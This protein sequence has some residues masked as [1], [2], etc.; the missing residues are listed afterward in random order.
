MKIKFLVIICCLF[1]S[2]IWS[3]ENGTNSFNEC[4]WETGRIFLTNIRQFDSPD[5]YETTVIMEIRNKSQL[6]DSTNGIYSLSNGSTHQKT[7]FILKKEKEFKIITFKNLIMSLKAVTSYLEDVKASD[8]EIV[9]YLEKISSILAH[10]R[11]TIR[12]DAVVSD[13]EWMVCN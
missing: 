2:S 11:K 10:N 6:E 7:Y 3:Q 13:G 8:K 9:E 5:E 4:I 12:N 1:I